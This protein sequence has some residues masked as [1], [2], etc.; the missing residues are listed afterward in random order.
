MCRW[1][2]PRAGKGQFSDLVIGDMGAGAFE[3][4]FPFIATFPWLC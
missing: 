3:I 2:R 1:P 4:P